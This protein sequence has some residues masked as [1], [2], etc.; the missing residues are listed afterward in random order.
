MPLLP[1]PGSRIGDA[2]EVFPGADY[3]DAEREF[4]MAI[5]RARR[6]GT[7]KLTYVD[8]LAIALSLGWKKTARPRKAKPPTHRPLQTA[9]SERRQ[10]RRV[11]PRQSKATRELKAAVLAS[12][13]AAG[14]PL[15]GRDVYLAVAARG[16]LRS[17]NTVNTALQ[18]LVR[19]GTLMHL[20]AG[21]SG[22]CGGYVRR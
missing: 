3:S 15:R 4:L 18:R 22:R 8:A 13:D 6:N 16:L 20:K 9:R 1:P 12:I 21:N 5:D 10:T 2:L 11:G 14:R 7:R 19:C 17:P